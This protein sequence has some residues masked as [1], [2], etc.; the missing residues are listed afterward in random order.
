MDF[1]NKVFNAW[2]HAIRGVPTEYHKRLADRVVS[3]LGNWLD[4]SKAEDV[5]SDIKYHRQQIDEIMVEDSQRPRY[6]K[7]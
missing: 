2:E 7:P 3:C 6:H 4:E 5:I 1:E